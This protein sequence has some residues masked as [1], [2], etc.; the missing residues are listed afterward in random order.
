MDDLE[1]RVHVHG[2]DGIVSV[3]A[4]LGIDMLV[5]DDAR[6]DV[7]ND[8]ETPLNDIREDVIDEIEDDL[9]MGNRSIPFVPHQVLESPQL[10]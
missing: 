5:L 2:H 9:R 8:L 4:V 6:I 7:R 1:Y 10:G 3:E